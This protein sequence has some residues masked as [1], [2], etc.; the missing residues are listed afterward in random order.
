MFQLRCTQTS[1]VCINVGGFTSLCPSPS[2]TIHQISGLEW[3]GTGAV[4][5]RQAE[6]GTLLLLIVKELMTWRWPSTTETC[7]HCQTN[8]SRSYNSCVLND[9]PTLICI[10]CTEQV[11]VLV[12]S[13]PPSSPNVPQDKRHQLLLGNLK[14]SILSRLTKWVG[15]LTCILK[16]DPG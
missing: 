11:D 2:S 16:E 9:R 3:L 4:L 15:I 7:S 5:E 14:S 13:N 8:K 10:L 12:T 6:K 1:C